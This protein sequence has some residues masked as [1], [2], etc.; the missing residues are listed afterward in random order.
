MFSGKES[1]RVF[2]TYHAVVII[3]DFCVCHHQLEWDPREWGRMSDLSSG[4]PKETKS[5]IKEHCQ[6]ADGLELREAGS[7]GKRLL[8]F[9]H[10]AITTLNLDNSLVEWVRLPGAV[11]GIRDGIVPKTH[12]VQTGLTLVGDNRRTNE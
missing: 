8:K 12:V 10:V 1:S 4:T 5:L 7:R 3:I 9:I 2:K 6:Q 11:L